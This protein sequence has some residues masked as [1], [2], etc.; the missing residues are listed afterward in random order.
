MSEQMRM[1]KFDLVEKVGWKD[2]RFEN[3]NVEL[4][5]GVCF[6]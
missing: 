3:N 6:L 2:E 5:A 4:S 1:A